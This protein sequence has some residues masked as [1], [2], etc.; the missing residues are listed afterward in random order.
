[1]LGGN[2]PTPTTWANVVILRSS[3]VCS[4]DACPEGSGAEPVRSSSACPSA[5][6]V[7]GCAPSAFTG[8]LGRHR[9]RFGRATSGQFRTRVETRAHRSHAGTVTEAE[10]GLPAH[11][12]R[13]LRRRLRLLG[14]QRTGGCAPVCA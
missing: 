5:S 11:L 6:A 8:G 4:G 2:A 3:A 1:M 13:M 9:F 12:E 14:K 10:R 7:T